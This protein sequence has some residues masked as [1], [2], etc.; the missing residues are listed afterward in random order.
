VANMS[1]EYGTPRDPEAM[2]KAH[3]LGMPPDV[4]AENAGLS[5]SWTIR[6]MKKAGIT[7]RKRKV[8]RELPVAKE[9]IVAAYR[10]DGKS[11]QQIADSHPNLYYKMVRN[12]LLENGVTLRPATQ[13]KKQG[14]SD[15]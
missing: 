10:D 12:V 3:E 6:K 2:R 11:I 7:P 4:I 14:R 1:S 13:P 15:D 9:D 5:L 8:R